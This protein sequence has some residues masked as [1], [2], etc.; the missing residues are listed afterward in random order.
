MMK[1]VSYQYEAIQRILY[2]LN[3]LQ[4][5]G[6]ENAQ[7]LDLTWT[8]L[9]DPLDVKEIKNDEQENKEREKEGD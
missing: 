1:V 4:V 5:T 7:R 3:D 8:I 2:A 9:K 6:P